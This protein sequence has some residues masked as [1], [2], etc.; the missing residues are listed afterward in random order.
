MKKIC[1]ITTIPLTLKTFVL[2][3]AEIH[4]ELLNMMKR[5]HVFCEEKGIRYSLC[6]GSLLG[7]IRHNGFIPWDDDIDIW[8][9]RENYEKLLKEID[10]LNGF[11]IHSSL[12]IMRLQSAAAWGG[13]YMM[14]PKEQDRVP[15]HLKQEQ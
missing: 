4:A 13:D 6:G 1:F 7:A 11:L 12:W 9:D 3:T 10:D 14:P 15:E 5:I 2:K 8:L